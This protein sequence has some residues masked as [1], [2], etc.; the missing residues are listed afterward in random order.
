[1]KKLTFI[2][3]IVLGSMTTYS[4]SKK[5]QIAELTFSYDSL[6]NV[7]EKERNSFNVKINELNAIFQQ[8][9][10]EIETLKI[11]IFQLNKQ[12]EKKQT[13]LIAKQAELEKQLAKSDSVSKLLTTKTQELEHFNAV[14]S[15]D[16]LITNNSVGYFKIGASWQNF[17]KDNYNYES[18]QGFGNCRDACCDGGFT[19][20]NNL[21]VN[22][23]GWVENPEITIGALHFGESESE[24]EHKNNPNVF[25][26]SSD[27][28][29]GW[30]WKNK[31]S[32]LMIYSESFKTKEGIGVGTTLEK[33]EEIFGKVIIN[34]GWLEEDANAIQIKVN[35]YPDIEFIL[36][37]DDAI[38][39]YEKLSTL[40]ENA[41]IS[42]FKKNTKIKRLFIN[43]KTN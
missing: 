31:I 14:P 9:K 7:L 20:G 38:G 16:Y 8:Q 32:Y 21:V 36:D 10:S 34:I 24:T 27:N 40:G 28:C 26:V 22:E 12:L 15:S 30:Y 37:V 39:G 1:M 41:I 13:E 11:E 5:E 25:Y 33:L 6:K 43:S 2:T 42:D 29:S 3:L 18:V 17:A 4:Q 19:L 35:S 23:Y